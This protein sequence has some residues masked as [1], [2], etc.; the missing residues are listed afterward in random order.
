MEGCHFG[1][2]LAQLAGQTRRLTGWNVV[3]VDPTG[4][5]SGQLDGQTG[6]L[7][8]MPAGATFPFHP[9]RIEGG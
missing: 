2:G 7:G 5:S 6:F 3:H 1:Q 4:V 8:V 9:D